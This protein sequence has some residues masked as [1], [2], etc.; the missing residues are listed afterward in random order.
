MSILTIKL[1]TRIPAVAELENASV[2]NV[3]ENKNSAEA[4]K[5]LCQTFEQ[6]NM[7]N[8]R[9]L[10]FSLPAKMKDI[11]RKP[12][13]DTTRKEFL[14]RAFR[15]TLNLHWLSLENNQIGDAGV[16]LITP[17]LK[18]M[19]V[20]NSLDLRDNQISDEGII[21]L[22]NT[23]QN[24]QSLK[25]LK[26][27]GNQISNSGALALAYLLLRVPSL[28]NLEVDIPNEDLQ[29]RLKAIA[30]EINPVERET[31]YKALKEDYPKI[32]EYE[33]RMNQSTQSTTA[34]HT[35]A[36]PLAFPAVY[37]PAGQA[38]VVPTLASA[39]PQIFQAPGYAPVTIHASTE[40]LDNLK[41]HNPEAF[42]LIQNFQNQTA[43]QQSPYSSATTQ[44]PSS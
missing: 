16:Q 34:F 17:L 39:A 41:R 15:N 2:I 22:T 33:Q 37:S 36:Q 26:L 5:V 21:V 9:V 1:P 27:K 18:N 35:P 44:A 30:K 7:R 23:L 10:S 38:S 25:E 14:A 29:K 13:I 8:L 40:A 11:F 19:R 24:T 4:F 42:Q 6:A 3:E 31:L 12:K 28:T 43:S 32:A 20:I